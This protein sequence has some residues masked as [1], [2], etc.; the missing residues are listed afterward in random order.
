MTSRSAG[1]LIY[2][3]GP[4]DALEVLLVHP[5][6]PF[7][8]ER[9]EGSWSIPKGEHGDDEDPRAAA[10]REVAEELGTPP[11]ARPGLDLGEVRQKGGKRVRCWAVPGDLDVE[12]IESNAFELE[13]PPRSG[14]FQTF[15]EVD[16]AAWFGLPEARV[17][18]LEG[19]RP[20]LDRLVEGLAGP[21]RVRPGGARGG[22]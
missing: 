16:R 1:L 2:R 5:G 10:H 3:Q 18:L 4:R 6:G 9:D 15:P 7:W 11:P 12:R 19:Q 17:K 22:T 20:F 14:R 8:A 13:W 21:E